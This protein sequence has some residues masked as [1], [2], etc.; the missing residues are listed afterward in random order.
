MLVTNQGC[1]IGAMLL[2]GGSIYTSGILST[3]TGAVLTATSIVVGTWAVFRAANP[4]LRLMYS[5]PVVTP[6]LNA[7]ADM[8]TDIEVRRGDQVFKSPRIVYF[9][10]AARGRR[11]ISRT[12][13]DDG[14][15]IRFDIGT[16]IVQCL[17]VATKPDDRPNPAHFIDE[18]ALLV[19]PCMIAR[20][21]Q[22]TFTLLVDGSEPQLTKP[23]QRLLDVRLEER[24]PA[25]PGMIRMLLMG[26]TSLGRPCDEADG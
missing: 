23:E 2:A 14:Q 22:T 13:F 4:K 1:L 5:I 18:S 6:M 15:P 9:K 24:D 3:V 11:D 12:A 10:L 7:V 16:P 25:A 19:G 21:Q 26:I 8:P 17:N 20:N